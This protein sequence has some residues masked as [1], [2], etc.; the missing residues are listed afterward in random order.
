MC[1]SIERVDSGGVDYDDGFTAHTMYRR[2]LCNLKEDTR[3][4]KVYMI[5]GW[6]L[7][8]LWATLPFFWDM[9]GSVGVSDAPSWMPSA[10]EIRGCNDW[11]L[12]GL[13]PM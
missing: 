11:D 3:L 7:P 13:G 5:V 8:G 4:L 9:W 6:V 12:K 1:R 10:L 2:I